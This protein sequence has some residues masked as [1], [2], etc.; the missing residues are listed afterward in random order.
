MAADVPNFKPVPL[1]Q[2]VLTLL[3]LVICTLL[4][5]LEYL[6][7]SVPTAHDRTG[8]AQEAPYVPVRE[9]RVA[10]PEPAPNSERLSEPRLSEPN[11]PNL[12]SITTYITR[13]DSWYGKSAGA[14]FEDAAISWRRR[15]RKVRLPIPRHR[16]DGRQL[17]LPGRPWPPPEL[18][19]AA[20]AQPRQVM[21]I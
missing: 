12:G 16:R 9:R 18:C 8:V 3:S 13:A 11:H 17:G 5:T 20:R 7:R 21:I 6:I 2:F 14:L 10:A 1:R 19:R 4:G 15:Q